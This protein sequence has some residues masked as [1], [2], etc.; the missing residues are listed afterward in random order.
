MY[1]LMYIKSTYPLL[2][3]MRFYADDVSFTLDDESFSCALN[4]LPSTSRYVVFGR[5]RALDISVTAAS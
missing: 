5:Q 2:F 3:T 4:S 1:V